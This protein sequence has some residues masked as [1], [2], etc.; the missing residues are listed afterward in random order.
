MKLNKKI[1]KNGL[2][3]LHE[4]RDV[5]VT[6]VML[7]VKYGSVYE[8]EKEKGI[9]HFIEHLCFKGTE[10]RTTRQIAFELEKVGGIENLKKIIEQIEVGLYKDVKQGTETK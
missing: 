3:V 9:A 10:K 7:G 4:K 5:P 6:T 8:D 2:T 1:L